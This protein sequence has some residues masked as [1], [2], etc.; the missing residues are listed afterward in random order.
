[1]RGWPERKR[2]VAIYTLTQSLYVRGSG[3]DPLPVVFESLAAQG[4]RL[5]HGQLCLVVAA[6]GVGK[7]AFVLTYALK[8]RVPT[9]YLSADSDAFTQLTRSVSILTGWTMDKSSQLVRDGDLNG[10]TPVLENVPIRFSYNSSPTLDQI[11]T[12][13]SSY[14]EVYG[15]YPT[16]V[17]VDNLTDVI[18]GGEANSEDPFAGLESLTA[19]LRDMARDTG[20]C[21][22]AT[23]HAT[24][25]YN[26][27]D[28]PIPRSGV[29]GQISRVPGLILTIH[30][31]ENQLR[32]STV[33][34]RNGRFDATGT[35]WVPL[36]FDGRTM[37]IKDL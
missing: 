6:P 28:K 7:S 27:G 5:L 23:H 22:I 32:V 21:V 15:D 18:T 8:A 2:G 11:E 10:A 36:S 16:L 3:G 37:S 19:Y 17:V 13:L 4:T 31:G 25:P 30:G 26:D 33:K 12:S 14:E 9:L 34:N 35:N 29:K 1:M 24:G 20:A